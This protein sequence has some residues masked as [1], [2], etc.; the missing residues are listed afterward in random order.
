MI[1]FGLF[2]VVESR[3]DFDAHYDPSWKRIDGALFFFNPDEVSYP[4]YLKYNE[5]WDPRDCG[6]NAITSKEEMENCLKNYIG[7]LQK[8]LDNL[9]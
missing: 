7:N 6:V 3:A 4:L 9:P 5:G 8:M 1:R 2:R